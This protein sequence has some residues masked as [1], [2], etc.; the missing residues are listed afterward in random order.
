MVD[1]FS[2]CLAD[3]GVKKGDAVAILLPNTVP[4]VAAYYAILKIGAI[5][6]M[7]NPL[8][9]D[10]ELEHQFNDSGSVALITVDL[11]VDRMA[12]LRSR[13]KIKQIVYTGIG[14]Y[15]PVVKRVLGRGSISTPM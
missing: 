13:T 14:D 8:Y 4:C 6:V 7:N 10:K 15:L 9:S 1:R 3:F 12:A 11:L 2:A 5:A